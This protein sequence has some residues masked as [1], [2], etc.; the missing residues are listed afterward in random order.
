MTWFRVDDGFPEHPKLEELE[1]EPARYMAA[2]TV[3]T[4]MGADCARRLTDG[5]VTVARLTKVLHR[6]G[7][8]ALI[9]AEALCGTG[10]WEKHASGWRFH[11]WRDY[12]PSRADVKKARRQKTERQRRWRNGKDAPT[13]EPRDGHVGESVDA[14]VDAS[15]QR[16]GDAPRDAA[17][18][19]APARASPDPTRPDPSPESKSARGRASHTQPLPEP[20]P[21][22][23]P[24]R[25]T[26]EL[27]RVAFARRFCEVT[28][29]PP[30]WSKKNVDLC[31]VVGNWLDAKGGD[32]DRILTRLLDG[33]FA[34]EWARDHGYPLGAL[35]NDP[36]KF[37]QPKLRDVTRGFVP[38]A[39]ASQFIATDP[40]SHFG[41]KP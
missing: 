12:Q 7:K 16:L 31:G 28:S 30:S 8:H 35:A 20:P 29:N 19:I 27:V 5:I 4:I 33:F 15:T 41:T 39:A 36:P 13:G 22:E 14:F 38:P 40:D 32:I 17:E 11:D 21:L 6:L 25:P 10:L 24:T 2:V 3:W 9:G 1:H 37:L 18:V 26:S 34:D 23:P